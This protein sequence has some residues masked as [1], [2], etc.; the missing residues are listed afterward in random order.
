MTDD[1]LYLPKG[2]QL[3]GSTT[4]ITCDYVGG[5]YVVDLPYNSPER[6][7]AR[8]DRHHEHPMARPRIMIWPASAGEPPKADNEAHKYPVFT[9]RE[10]D[11][12]GVRVSR[13]RSL[14]DGQ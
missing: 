2:F 1:T 5:R 12:L 9:E 8:I 10:L 14:R 3:S 11:E 13:V 6:A 4:W 7:L